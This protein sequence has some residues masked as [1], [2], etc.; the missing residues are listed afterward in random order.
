MRRHAL[1]RVHSPTEALNQLM[2]NQAHPTFRYAI[3][4]GTVIGS[5]VV[6]RALLPGLDL[7][8][9][10]LILLLV[11]FVLAL[12]LG[13]G[14]AVAAALLSFLT[15]NYFFIPPLQNL[16]VAQGNNV[17]AL[18]VYLGIAIVTG[19]LVARVRIRSNAA[20][21][22]QRRT[23]LLYELN[24]ALISDITPDAIL[25]TIVEQIVR[26]YRAAECRIL[27]PEGEQFK[28]QARFPASSTQA[29]DRQ[30]DAMATWVLEHGSNA[31]QGGDRRRLR[32]P[33]GTVAPGSMPKWLPERDRLYMPIATSERKFGVLEIAG[34]PG[35]GRFED[36]DVKLLS[37][38]A[39]QAALA[40]ERAHLTEEVG[41]AV[42][43]SE[44]DALK[45]ALLAT[46]SHDLRTPLAAIKAS[47]TSLLD[48]SVD[49]PVEAREELLHAIDEETDRLTLMVGN[50]LDL[51]RIEGGA[52]TPD[53]G[54]YDVAEL[55]ADVAHR[56]SNRL[57]QHPLSTDV[58]PMLPLVRFD[59]IEILQV[60]TNLVENAVKYT[61]PETSFTIVAR[62][63]PRAVEIAVHDGGTG[64]SPDRLPYL[65]EKFYRGEPAAKVAGTGI[66]LTISRGLVEA[67]GGSLVAESGCGTGTTF[68]FTLPLDEDGAVSQ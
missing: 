46:V 4:L 9:V 45:S 43:L 29:I 58:E 41:R 23:A 24:A 62:R 16:A 52:L 28:V 56:L 59:Y 1:W 61:P 11:T 51:S 27:L 7:L 34:R 65:F 35:G 30:Q 6:M 48:T 40:L 12:I 18:A 2:L 10:S 14:P 57:D 31:H 63:V 66:G 5:A 21:E 17:L 37:A 26:V 67:H 13:S 25:G 32:F 8:N 38:F 55:V 49:W 3:A 36:A 42:I 53:K 50:L 22:D 44:S 54:W 20:I 47:A 33:H 68:R 39:N 19:Q 15:L 60:M 64:I